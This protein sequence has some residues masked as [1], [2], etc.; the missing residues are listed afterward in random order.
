[1]ACFVYRPSIFFHVFNIFY[2]LLCVVCI[3]YIGRLICFLHFFADRIKT[4][5]S[6]DSDENI[7]AGSRIIQYFRTEGVILKSGA[8]ID[9]RVLSWIAIQVDRARM[10]RSMSGAAYAFHFDTCF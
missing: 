8:T 5:L 1:M 9:A 6:V 2:H 4:H 10:R 3:K 7:G